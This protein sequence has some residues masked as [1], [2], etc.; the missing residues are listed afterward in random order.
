M[1]TAVVA[2]GSAQPS[3][4]ATMGNMPPAEAEASYPAGLE[5]V[6]VAA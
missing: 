1:S 3:R 5:P 2:P 6:P 4:P